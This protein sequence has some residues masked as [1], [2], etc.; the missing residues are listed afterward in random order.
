MSQIPEGVS[1]D[2]SRDSLAA[3]FLR[4]FYDYWC[5][6]R[7]GAAMAPVSAIDP[8]RLPRSCL[9]H[10]S[11]LEIEPS[12]FRLRPRLMGTTLVEQ[13]GADL[14]GRYLDEVPGM[15][16]QLARMEWCARSGQPY[17]AGDSITFAP[18]D[19]RRYQ[20]LILPFGDAEHGVQRIVGAFCFPDAP[21]TS[22]FQR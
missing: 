20:V 17:L 22:P 16:K 19:F 9:P 14:T 21:K 6:A 12:P 2:F 5:A 1:I 11:V 18:N 3:D 10:L 4:D 7:G 15:A 13:L 8:M